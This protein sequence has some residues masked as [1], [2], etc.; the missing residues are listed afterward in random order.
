MVS[1]VTGDLNAF[2]VCMDRKVI[3]I[4]G[5]YL[6]RINVSVTFSVI[7]LSPADSVGI[8]FDDFLDKHR[9]FGLELATPVL[10]SDFLKL[11]VKVRLIKSMEF[12]QSIGALDFIMDVIKKGY[13]IPFIP[14]PPPKHYSNNASAFREVD[15]VDQAIAELLADNRVEELRRWGSDTRKFGLSTELIM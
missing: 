8:D 14:T 1:L 4:A 12:W 10:S 6:L 2:R 15:F 7:S 9:G 11:S 3:R 5:D 13:K